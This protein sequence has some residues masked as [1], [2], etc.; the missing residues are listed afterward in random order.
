MAEIPG[1]GW[2][3]LTRQ[4]SMPAIERVALIESTC[5][6]GM[7]FK[8]W[9]DEEGT[10]HG[11]AEPPQPRY[12]EY[13]RIDCTLT[14]QQVQI[15]LCVSRKVAGCSCGRCPVCWKWRVDVGADMKGASALYMVCSDCWELPD[16]AL[17]ARA[18]AGALRA[19]VEKGVGI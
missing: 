19:A 15:T 11:G 6:C 8:T 9:V 12:F 1:A 13:P 17:G 14:R 10:N 3:A 7:S 4:L 16:A 18:I 2:P 5:R